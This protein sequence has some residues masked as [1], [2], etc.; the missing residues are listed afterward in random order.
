MDFKVRSMGPHLDLKPPITGVIMHHLP[1]VH[2][3]FICSE[4]HFYY[5]RNE[6]RGR[7]NFKNL[8]G[9]KPLIGLN[10]ALG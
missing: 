7:P 9:T 6:V 4:V 5:D 2:E 10:A 1:L 3:F 8:R